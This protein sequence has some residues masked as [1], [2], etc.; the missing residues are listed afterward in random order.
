MRPGTSLVFAF[1]R[2]SQQGFFLARLQA[3]FDEMTHRLA[4]TYNIIRQRANFLRGSSV[5][6]RAK[7]SLKNGRR[8]VNV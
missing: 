2:V 1:F 4:G 3:G 5:I 6:I 8:L 7:P